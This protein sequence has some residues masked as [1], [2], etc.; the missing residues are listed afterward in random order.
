MKKATPPM[1]KSSIKNPNPMS[2]APSSSR[3]KTTGNN[4][5]VISPK[6]ALKYK[7]PQTGLYTSP[8][9]R[10]GKVAAHFT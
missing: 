7:A 8:Q 10:T 3:G 6:S 1:R 9:G 2:V 4:S 5:T